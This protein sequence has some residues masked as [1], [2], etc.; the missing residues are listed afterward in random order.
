MKLKFDLDRLRCDCGFHSF[1]L[2]IVEELD[3][4]TN[5]GV[6]V[7]AGSWKGVGGIE[8]PTISFNIG[9]TY[10]S[11][12]QHEFDTIE[13]Q[14]DPEEHLRQLVEYRLKDALCSLLV[15]LDALLS[16]WDN[17]L[18]HTWST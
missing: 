10:F 11:I 1:A 15:P 5:G 4:L 18:Y 3:R 17:P 13:R 14:R 9:L 8:L 6:K 16:D 2:S 12:A 7:G